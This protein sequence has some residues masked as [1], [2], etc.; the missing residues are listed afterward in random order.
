MTTFGF[1]EAEV[2]DLVR[3]VSTR[4]LNREQVENRFARA[5]WSGI[6]EPGDGAAGIL[7][8]Q[9]GPARALAA[10][11]EQ[12]P[13]SSLATDELSVTQVQ[14][15]LDRWMPRLQP[16]TMLQ[17]LRHAARYGARLRTPDDDNWPSGFVGL[18]PHRPVALWTRGRDEALAALERSIALVGARA[19]TGYGEHMTMEASAGLV[20]RGF[21]IVSGAAYGIDGMAHRAALAS[22]GHT[23]AFLAGGVDR[24]YPSG[25]DALLT[26]I[27]E[28]GLVAS[29][30]PCG[31]AP[32]RWRFLQ[33]NRLIAA[34][35]LATV[36][37]EAGWRSGSLNTAHHALTAGRPVGAVPGPVTSAASAGCHRLIRENRAELVTGPDDMA[38][39][40]GGIVTDSEDRPRRDDTRVLDALS[41][42]VPRHTDDIAARAGLSVS[43]TQAELGR[44]QLEEVIRLGERG[45]VKRGSPRVP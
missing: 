5:M 36:V 39:L 43:E 41:A 3:A 7:V 34:S 12:A 20:D 32:T 2:A 45:W 24:F 26:R 16:A 1:K 25:H 33:R 15:G 38:E 9:L 30:L 27:V 4:H 10:L 8:D 37:M 18:G 31:S 44:L 6:T 13:A 17:W 28:N 42:R 35:S 11:V 21:A 40:A 14:E 29:E 23:I 19:A 22:R